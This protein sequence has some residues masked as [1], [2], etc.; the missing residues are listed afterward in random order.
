M[1]INEFN[2]IP[3][4][5]TLTYVRAMETDYQARTYLQDDDYRIIAD[6]QDAQTW[7]EFYAL[8]WTKA[9]LHAGRR[10]D[11]AKEYEEWARADRVE[12]LTV[13]TAFELGWDRQAVENYF[14][15]DVWETLPDDETWARIIDRIDD[16][17]GDFDDAEIQAIIS[18]EMDEVS[19]QELKDMR[20]A[21]G[22]SQDTLADMLGVRQPTIARWE[23]GERSV[24][25]GLR[26]ELVS[27]IARFNL[28][29]ER[30]D[31][32]GPWGPVIR[33]WAGR[34]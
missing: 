25:R 21:L 18:E 15:F 23:S 3:A 8:G 2:D 10:N 29:L 7:H 5:A 24:P 30:R 32:S 31:T 19:G 26:S 13:E 12:Y 28:D 11:W 9:E 17:D 22:L 14:N 1:E 4:T 27:I 6:T 20:L 34:R 33:F 16:L